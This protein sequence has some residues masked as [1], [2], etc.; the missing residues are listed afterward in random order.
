MYV[1]ITNLTSNNILLTSTSD[2]YISY[3]Y[4]KLDGVNTPSDQFSSHYESFM[5][6]SYDLCKCYIDENYVTVYVTITK[7]TFS[8]Y[9]ATLMQNAEKQ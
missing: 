7:P 8:S 2:V 3:S 4:C 6:K 9:Y 1:D 5:V